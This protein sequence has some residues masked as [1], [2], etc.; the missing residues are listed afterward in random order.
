MTD[1]N[2]SLR[3]NGVKRTREGENVAPRHTLDCSAVR[4]SNHLLGRSC[5]SGQKAFTNFRF[6][7]SYLNVVSGSLQPPTR[8]M[9][10]KVNVSHSVAFKHLSSM[11]D[12][13]KE[14]AGSMQCLTVVWPPFTARHCL[15]LEP[16]RQCSFPSNPT[17]MML[18]DVVSNQDINILLLE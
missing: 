15:L 1:T 5:A 11:P 8:P 9:F 3:S 10:W 2:R 12:M 13:E 7:R 6:S 14:G 17:M 16:W 18:S 4:S